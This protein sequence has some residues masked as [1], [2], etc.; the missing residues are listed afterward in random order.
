[1]CS[2]YGWGLI[3]PHLAF[4]YIG[5][6]HYCNKPLEFCVLNLKRIHCSTQD[7][8]VELD[9]MYCRG[10]WFVFKPVIAIIIHKATSWDYPIQGCK[11]TA[12]FTTETHWDCIIQ[13]F[14][15]TM[16]QPKVIHTS[17]ILILLFFL[18]AGV[19]F[20]NLKQTGRCMRV[21]PDLVWILFVPVPGI[22]T[23]EAHKIRGIMTYNSW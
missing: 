7:S 18:L 14:S 11:N 5:K 19:K 20:I 6:T 2:M 3:F 8:G 23:R 1:M 22:T 10:N 21:I 16:E 4:V 17:F 13:L 12:I 9:G 15:H